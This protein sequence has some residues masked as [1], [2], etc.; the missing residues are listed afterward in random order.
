MLKVDTDCDKKL[1]Y[2]GCQCSTR[3]VDGVA[4]QSNVY[5]FVQN[6]IFLTFKYLIEVY[7]VRK[8]VINS[9]W[10]D[11]YWQ[12]ADTYLYWHMSWTNIC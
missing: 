12:A 6:P 10:L 2:I 8:Y 3:P 4:C 1:V 11:I 7:N 9:R 5:E